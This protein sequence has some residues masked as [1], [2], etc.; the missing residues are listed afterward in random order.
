MDV[1][2]VAI[3]TV[4]S[5]LISGILVLNNLCHSTHACRI[6][7]KEIK[8]RKKEFK[9][10]MS[11]GLPSGVQSAMFSISNLVMQSSFNSFGADFVAGNAAAANIGLT[12]HFEYKDGRYTPQYHRYG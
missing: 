4:A 2:G 12:V 1:D 8:I 10:I 11:L 3:A 6:N 9:R 5:N 7:P